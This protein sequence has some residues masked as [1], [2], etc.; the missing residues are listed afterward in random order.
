MNLPT[1][2]FNWSEQLE[3]SRFHTSLGAAKE[4]NQGPSVCLKTRLHARFRG[5]AAL[6]ASGDFCMASVR[7][8]PFCTTLEPL[9]VSQ[10]EILR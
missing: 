5:R 7:C 1:V 4:E 8:L 2:V 3:T 10:G 6:S 9:S